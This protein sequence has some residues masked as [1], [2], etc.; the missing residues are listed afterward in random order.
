MNQKNLFTALFVIAAV[1]LGTIATRPLFVE[2]ETRYAEIA[3]EMIVSHDW[4]SPKLNGLDYFEKPVMGHWMNAAAMTVF[5]E[6]GFSVRFF[7]AFCTILTG[8]MLFFWMKKTFRSP[9][10]AGIAAM[11]YFSSGLVF[12]VGTYAVLDAQLSFFT[13]LALMSA[14]SAFESQSRLEKCGLLTLFGLAIGGA[15]LV[16]GFVALALIGLPAAGYLLWRRSWREMVLAP[17]LPL[18]VAVLAVLPWSILIARRSPDFWNYF[19]WIEHVQRF[20]GDEKGQHPEGPWFFLLILPVGMMPWTLFFPAAFRGF[21]RAWKREFSA[22]PMQFCACSIILPFIF[23]SACSGKLATYILP[24]FPFFAAV[25]AV[26]LSNYAKIDAKM[27]MIDR[28]AR[29]F[30]LLLTAALIS[31]IIYQA[32]GFVRMT[33]EKWQVYLP[34]EKMK[35]FFAALG[36]I[37]MMGCWKKIP[38]MDSLTAKMALAAGGTAAVMLTVHFVMPYRFVSKIAPEVFYAP[39]FKNV[40]AET[41]VAAFK[42]LVGATC[43]MLKRDDI[44]VYESGGELAYGLERESGRGRLLTPEAF[45]LMV[46]DPSNHVVVVMDSERRMKKLPSSPIKIWD[47]RGLLYQE[48]NR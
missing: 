10:L 5:G 20:L 16:K 29:W 12:A 1:Y 42:K 28:A 7:P 15:F 11:I 45:R 46:A 48:Y 24:L 34:A 36:A 13:T 38:K 41:K 21:H 14:F 37:I 33:P 39:Y 32:C 23:L 44:L 25:M 6:N 26:G 8:M 9:E 17:W 27:A 30:S 35:F 22:P 18:T 31:F 3:R 2:D 40:T 19:F 4:V 43:W 47:E